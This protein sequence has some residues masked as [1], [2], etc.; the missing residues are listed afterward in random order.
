VIAGE[1]PSSQV[2]TLDGRSVATLNGA[3]VAISVDGDTVLLQPS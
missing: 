3:D 2:V 1:V